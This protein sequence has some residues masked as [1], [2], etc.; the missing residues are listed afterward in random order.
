MK[1]VGKINICK[2][3]RLPFEFSCAPFLAIA[4]TRKIVPETSSDES[5]IKAQ[6]PKTSLVNG[7][8][9]AL[10]QK[11]FHLQGWLSNSPE[12]LSAVARDPEKRSLLFKSLTP[13]E[14]E[15]KGIGCCLESE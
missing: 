15:R 14:T 7:V 6:S 13:E 3:V 9:D 12:L 4:A 10:A 8:K 2:I 1:S 5:V 11:V